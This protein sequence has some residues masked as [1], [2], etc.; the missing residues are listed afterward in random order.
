MCC[1]RLL[2]RNQFPMG[3]PQNL[4]LYG[5]DA[6]HFPQPGLTQDEAYQH[7][8]QLLYVQFVGL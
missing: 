2:E 8:P 7:G 4:V 1:V 3:L 6:D 5:R